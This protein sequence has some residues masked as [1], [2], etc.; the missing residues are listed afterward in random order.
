[1]SRRRTVVWTIIASGAILAAIVWLSVRHWRP[2]WSIV[3]GAV[4]RRDADPRKESPIAD[5]LITA[6]YGTASLNT[7]TGANGY[8][9]IAF[10]GT[11]LPGQT[12]TLI[13]HRRDYQTLEMSVPIRFRSSLRQLV[14]AAMTPVSTSQSNSPD[15]PAT[16][17]SNIRVRYTENSHSDENIGSAVRTFEVVNRD[18][19]PCQHQAPC[20]PDGYWK[21]STSSVTLDAGAGNEFRNARA[22][23]IAGPCP[24]TQIDSSGFVNG[25]RTIVVSAT[26][27]SNTATFLVQ[28]EVFHTEIVS[29]VRESYPVVFGR[30]LNFSVPPD[31]EGVSLATE[32]NGTQIV[33]PLGPDQYLSWAS[34]T[35]RSGFDAEKSATYQCEL[36]PG[37]RF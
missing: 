1:M 2:R 12:V 9:R 34:C 10:P 21:A 24:F 17:I 18:N 33:F 4:I 8:F 14:V 19:I 20:S 26:D 32:L 28:A 22:S 7:Q 35:G 29:E 3:Q 31:A 36:K 16:V 13:F 15:H 23:C 5:V 30:T 37:F 11:V 27:W 25:G 6:S